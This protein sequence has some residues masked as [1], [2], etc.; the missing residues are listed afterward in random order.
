[1]IK[2]LTLAIIMT[3]LL[4]G[5]GY[6]IAKADKS[7]EQFHKKAASQIEEMQKN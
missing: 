7:Q 6:G 1:M 5:M 2:R 3:L 4:I